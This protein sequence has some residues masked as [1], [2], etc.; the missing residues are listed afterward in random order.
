MKNDAS[1]IDTIDRPKGKLYF[2]LAVERGGGEGRKR[3]LDGKRQRNF[4]FRSALQLVYAIAASAAELAASFA[5]VS[6]AEDGGRK[7]GKKQ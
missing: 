1:K 3:G 6:N 7:E 5:A 2:H 4:Q